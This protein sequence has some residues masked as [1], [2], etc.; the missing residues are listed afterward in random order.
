MFVTGHVLADALVVGVPLFAVDAAVAVLVAEVRQELEEDLVL[1]EL[2]A[3]H[4]G[5][6]AR[7][8]DSLEV[9]GRNRVRFVPEE[10]VESSVD[11]LLA[12]G[13]H[14]SLNL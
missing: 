11:E 1:G 5:V 4:L 7:L 13:A 2:S 12:L 8:V 3:D 14:L 10:P 9:G 6:Q